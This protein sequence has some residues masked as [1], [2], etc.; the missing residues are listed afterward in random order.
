MIMLKSELVKV[1]DVPK[2]IPLEIDFS[3][4]RRYPF[5]LNATLH[6]LLVRLGARG[7]VA[8]GRD[9]EKL[10]ALAALEPRVVRTV[11]IAGDASAEA[12]EIRGGSG[13]ADVFLDL[14]PP[15]SAA[16]SHLAAGILALR[17]GGRAS[18]MGGQWDEPARFPS[19]AITA[20]DLR[21][22]GKWMY[23]RADVAAFLR[24]VEAGAVRLGAAGGIT[25]AG[26]FGLDEFEEAFQCAAR[27]NRATSLTVI[28]P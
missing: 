9:A 21:L 12:A 18:L 23:E 5:V 3:K 2:N 11:R 22:C 17:R 10:S 20:N 26:R 24:L 25:V 6:K 16:S 13:P 15:G 1:R 14:A 8:M 4:A 7:V 19:F 28:V 27:N